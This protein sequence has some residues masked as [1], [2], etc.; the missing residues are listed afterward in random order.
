MPAPP[1]QTPV[2]LAIPPLDYI[3]GIADLTGELVRA[4][5]GL[6][7]HAQDMALVARAVSPPIDM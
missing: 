4:L 5:H 3:L 2:T 7:C 1:L 6:E